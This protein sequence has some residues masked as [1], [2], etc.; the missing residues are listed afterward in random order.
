M[1]YG[2]LGIANAAALLLCSVGRNYAS[3]KAAVTFH[4]KVLYSVLR[5][6]VSFFETTPLGR[7]VNRFA[8]DITIVDL[9]VADTLHM[10]AFAIIQVC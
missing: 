10:W 2:L 4:T 3:I 5:S 6:P 8:K 1:V 7:I 9:M